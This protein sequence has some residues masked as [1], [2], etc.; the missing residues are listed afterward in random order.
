M[1]SSRR[2]AVDSAYIKANASLDSLVEKEM[3][4]DAQVFTDE[5]ESKEDDPQKKD[6]KLPAQEK[7]RTASCVESKKS[8]T[9]N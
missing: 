3:L 6:R 4:D 1:V 2:Q 5:L 9:S 7:S 8:I